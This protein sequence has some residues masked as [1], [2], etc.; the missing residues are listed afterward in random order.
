MTRM[1]YPAWRAA[2]VAAPALLVLAVFSAVLVPGAWAQGAGAPSHA[3]GGEAS[4][5]VPDLSQVAF[6]GVN[7]RVLLMLGFIVCAF[8]LFFGL[9]IFTQLKKL[10]VH[11][12]MREISELIY[13][14][15]K[16]YLI[17]Q[18]KLLLILE[19]F[20]DRKSVV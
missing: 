2:F 6:G 13:E 8:G 17:T 14:T 7:G 19:A 20:I 4:L 5:I 18:G 12:T 11:E 10:P 3:G 15:C 9:V 16:T 1:P